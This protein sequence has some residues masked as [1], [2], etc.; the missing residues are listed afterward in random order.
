MAVARGAARGGGAEQRL[1]CAGGGAA[2]NP[3]FSGPALPLWPALHPPEAQPAAAS[4]D[5]AARGALSPLVAAIAAAR[6]GKGRRDGGDGQLSS[7]VPPSPPLVQV[8]GHGHW[9]GAPPES[10]KVAATV[11]LRLHAATVLYLLL[12]A[13]DVGVPVDT[14]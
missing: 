10:D 13:S 11:G 3:P 12:L 5:A 6:R 7:S 4:V 1:G 9:L 8:D 2:A 14:F